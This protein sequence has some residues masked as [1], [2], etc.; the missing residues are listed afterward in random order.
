MRELEKEGVRERERS[1]K[2]P[3]GSKVHRPF[4]S[5]KGAAWSS[6][7]STF[8]DKKVLAQE[9]PLSALPQD[10]RPRGKGQPT[11]CVLCN[12]GVSSK[13]ARAERWYR[14]PGPPCPTQ[15]KKAGRAIECDHCSYAEITGSVRAAQTPCVGVLRESSVHFPMQGEGRQPLNSSH[16]P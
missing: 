1:V 8:C 14:P 15:Q 2:Q 4:T 5:A 16:H 12:P 10:R 13:S 6:W 7:L 3:S 9:S 11:G